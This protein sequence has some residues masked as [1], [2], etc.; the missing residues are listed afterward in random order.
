MG[1]V[2]TVKELFD[3]VV[4]LNIDEN[5]EEAALEKLNEKASLRTEDERSAQEIVEA[6]VFKKIFIPRQLMDVNF[7]ERA[8]SNV[9]KDDTE[10]VYKSVTGVQLQQKTNETLELFSD[11]DEDD[12]SQIKSDF[13][14]STSSN[15]DDNSKFKDSHRPR[16]ESPNSRKERKKA[17][18]AETAEKRKSKV[19]KHVKK[20]KE[21]VSS[22]K[23]K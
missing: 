13:D 6:E 14:S 16:N 2:L 10:P 17:L 11:K 22:T 19:K 15:E 23:K 3:F 8:I 21:K 4:D 1:N 20:R 18:K 7:P 9:N 12:K 5:N